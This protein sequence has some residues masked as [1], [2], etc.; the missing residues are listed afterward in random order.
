MEI[1]V[2]EVFVR[3]RSVGI[4]AILVAS[5]ALAQTDRGTI[6]GT[7][8][9][10]TGAVVPGA[11]VQVTNT[12]TGAQYETATTAT[13]NYTLASLVAGTYNLT[14]AVTG[15]KRFTQ[16][17]IQVAV[18]QT[19]R[20]DVVLEI[21][22][23]S[24]AVTI[25]ADAPL[26]KTENAEQSFYIVDER[27]DALPLPPLVT[28]N[29]L[30]WA[31]LVPGVVGKTNGAAGSSTIKVNGS[32][33][34]TYKVMVDG[35]DI[36]SSIDPSHT[37]EQQPS[38]EA[39]Q[40]F[41]LQSSNFAAE[42]GQVAGGLFNFTSKS[43]TNQIHGSAY[44]YFRNEALNAASPYTHLDPKS[45]I[46][47]WGFTVGGPVYIPKVYDG[48]N[49][50][51]FFVSWEKYQTQ[52]Y[53]ASYITLPTAAMRTGDFSSVLTGR[54]LGTDIIGR[55]ILE[56]TIYD[57]TTVRTANGQLVTDPFPGNIIPQSRLNPIAQKIVALV[58]QPTLNQQLLNF[59]QKCSIP[60]VRNLP[61][62]KIDQNFG[63]KSKLSF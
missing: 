45:R 32:P 6:T 35:Q 3:I 23:A 62:V 25:T 14:V 52:D 2:K 5:A 43:G 21:G 44:S 15:F 54:N 19:A 4:V 36:T 10:S 28:R 55:A 61:T 57:P 11:T 47:N 13:G 12:E 40:E 38:V 16:E 50:T 20:V 56:N 58:P 59:Q 37:L 7:L 29:P 24:D 42:F 27:I 1:P 17:G 8:A 53:L 31:G 49:K 30:N 60:D 39:L 46:Y 22:A 33:A 9:D 51:F 34:T 18:A 63:A 26:L 48:R 41:T